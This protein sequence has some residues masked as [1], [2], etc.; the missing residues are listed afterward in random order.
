VVG[1]PA[2]AVD[3][4]AQADNSKTAAWF[5]NSTAVSSLSRNPA[6]V[7]NPWAASVAMNDVDVA[8]VAVDPSVASSAD[9]LDIG[10]IS[11]ITPRANLSPGQTVEFTGRTSGHKTVK[12][13]GLAVVFRLYG[14]GQFYCFRNLFEVRARSIWQLA[15][16][17]P[18][19]PGDSGAWVCNATS[20]G[21]GWCGMVI[22]GDRISGY[23]V[24]SQNIETWCNSLGLAVSV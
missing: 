12:V 22:G 1:S 13:G 11:S 8:L 9:V 7:C 17:R 16:S 23:A 2:L 6:A 5:G 21:F 18:V 19:R 20:G 4:P 3:Q 10:T 14:N 15:R 24:F